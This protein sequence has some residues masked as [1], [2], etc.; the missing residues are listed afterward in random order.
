MEMNSHNNS[1]VYGK[2]RKPA[3]I[4]VAGTCVA[5]SVKGFVKDLFSNFFA[6]LG[7]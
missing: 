4:D 6:P 5:N 2:E 3:P 1:P 7:Q